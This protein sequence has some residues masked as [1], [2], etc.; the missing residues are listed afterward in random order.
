LIEPSFFSF[1]ERLVRNQNYYEDLKLENQ[2]WPCKYYREGKLAHAWHDDV[3]E[4]ARQEV[5][6]IYKDGYSRA[7]EELTIINRIKLRC[8]VLRNIE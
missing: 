4:K 3:V 6:Q 2:G 8:K 5:R 1:G 7:K